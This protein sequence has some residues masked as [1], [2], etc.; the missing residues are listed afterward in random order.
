[1]YNCRSKQEKEEARERKRGRKR[2]ERVNKNEIKIWAKKVGKKEQGLVR[3]FK[4]RKK[5]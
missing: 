1:L 5:K 4:K 2:N 3:C